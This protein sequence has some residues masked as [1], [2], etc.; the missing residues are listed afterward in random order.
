MI[1][2]FKIKEYKQSE[3]HKADKYI[4]SVIPK[5]DYFIYEKGMSG[6]L[7]YYK[8]NR[9]PEDIEYHE[10]FGYAIIDN[11]LY[12]SIW[13]NK[14]DELITKEISDVQIQQSLF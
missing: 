10:M 1:Y 11:E 7:V 12:E 3:V 14:Y 6:S 13:T 8:S 5:A 9:Q 4:V 2:R